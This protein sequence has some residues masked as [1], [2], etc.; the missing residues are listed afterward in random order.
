MKP[1]ERVR[2]VLDGSIPDRVPLIIGVSNATGIKMKAYRAFKELVGLSEPDRY[3][4]DWPELGTSLPG[5]AGLSR[6]RSDVR[7]VHDRFPS[8][9]YELNRLRPPHDPF[10]DSW[11]SGAREISPGEWFPGVHPLAGA[12]TTDELLAYDGWPDMDDPT[13]FSHIGEDA[14]SIAAKGTHAIMATP[15]LL[16]PLERAFAMQGMD[17][18]LMNLAVHPEFA[19]ALLEKHL[20]LCKR[21]MGHVLEELGDNVDIIKIGD[22]L[23]TQDNLLMSPAMYREL[24][25][26]IHAEFIRFIRSRTGAR[27]FF[28]TDGDVFDLIP[29][30]LE[31]GVDILN[32]IQ[33]SAGR[34]SDLERL[35]SD[36][37]GAITFCGAVDTHHVLPRGT[38]QDVRDEVRRVIGI[39]G[40][41]G[42]YIAA[43]VH[44]IMNDVPAENIIAMVDA[45]QA[46]GGY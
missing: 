23:G 6:L 21:L 46:H 32:P 5:E 36:F 8:R 26:P 41:G 20:E 39:L 11:G 1:R 25:K 35:K 38:P 34:M 42:G 3:L 22:D 28:H 14:E 19:V 33:T 2:A 10:V 37:G 43:S 17:T 40:R 30:F 12:T 4:Y 9:V 45:V 16:F 18:F 24:L 13:R 44:T 7:G 27:V 31:M 29:D 15:W